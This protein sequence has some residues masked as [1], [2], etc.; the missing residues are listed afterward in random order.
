M[1]EDAAGLQWLTDAS[2][3]SLITDETSTGEE[4]SII[5][6][7]IEPKINAVIN[8]SSV[9]FDISVSVVASLSGFQGTATTKVIKESVIKQM[10]KEIRHT[11]AKGLEIDADVYRFSEVLYRKHNR[12]WKKYEENGKIKLD[13][14]SL[15]NVNIHITKVNAGRKKFDDY[16]R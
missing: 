7:K 4:I 11:Y 13:E 5:I 12:E 16:M 14:K 2:Q 6:T 10:E 3:R 1:D 15:R 8:H 9:Q